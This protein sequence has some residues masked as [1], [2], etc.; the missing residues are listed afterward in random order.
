[1]THIMDKRFADILDTA[2]ELM[3]TEEVA[4][5]LRVSTA[6]VIRWVAHHDLRCVQVG[7]KLH[8]FPKWCVQE[9]VATTAKTIADK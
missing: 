9:F 8:R 7:S 4:Q 3:T 2:P 5:L 6:T 1:M